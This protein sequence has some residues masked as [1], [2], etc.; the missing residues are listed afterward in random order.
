MRGRRRSFQE[1]KGW[2][3]SLSWFLFLPSGFEDPVLWRNIRW[4]KDREAKIK[5][6]RK[7]SEK[8]RFRVGVL[9]EKPPHSHCTI[10]SPSRGIA[11]ARFVIT[12][13]PQKD[14]CPQ[15]KTYPRKAVPIRRR[16]ITT[17]T[18]QTSIFLNAR[19]I[20]DREMWI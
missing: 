18:V 13:A 8:N 5:G 10:F 11:E 20:N 16:S 4:I 9:T 1:K 3:F 7:W 2:K 17:P 15:G 14:I 19:F 6:R 12:V